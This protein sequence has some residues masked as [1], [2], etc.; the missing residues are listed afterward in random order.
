[1]NRGYLYVESLVQPEGTYHL[2]MSVDRPDPEQMPEG[3]KLLYIASFRDIDAAFMHATGKLRSRCKHLD[4]ETFVTELTTVI[5]VI[6]ADGL[7]HERVW[8]ADVLDGSEMEVLR[9]LTERL[10]K[11]AENQALLWKM[12]GIVAVVIFLLLSITV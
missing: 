1:M 4:T 6:E 7:S 3:R 9:R 8:L 10:Q 11:Q 5:A 12:V 2:A